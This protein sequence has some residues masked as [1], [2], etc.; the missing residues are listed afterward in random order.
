MGESKSLFK[1]LCKLGLI[2][3]HYENRSFLT[4]DSESLP[5][6]I[7]VKYSRLFLALCKPGFNMNIYS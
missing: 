5:F 6:R 1:A 7:S 4:T 2:M 3:D